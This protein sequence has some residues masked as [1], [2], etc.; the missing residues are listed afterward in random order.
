MIPETLDYDY[1][2]KVISNTMSAF[3]LSSLFSDHAVLCRNKE[4]RVFGKAGNGTNIKITLL[5]ASGILLAADTVQ[6]NDG[7]F[8]AILPPQE[9]AVHCTLRASDGHTETI[10]CDIAIGDVFLA[11]GQSNMELE[12]RNADDGPDAV[13]SHENILVRYYNVPRCAVNGPD[14]DEDNRN[15]HWQ[16][17]LPG[18][19]RDMSAVAYFFAMK[20]QQEI[21]VPIGIIDCYWGGSSISC[22]MTRNTLESIAE[23]QRY[24]KDYSQRA[25]RKTMEQYLEEEKIFLPS[26]HI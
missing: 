23:G 24:L 12:L 22:W 14:T 3:E 17:I 1:H 15:A 10:A 16:E 5:S 18:E 8:T 13:K 19:G 11:G 2:R 20:L 7:C 21:N 9:A 6:A 4:I 25:G 26:S